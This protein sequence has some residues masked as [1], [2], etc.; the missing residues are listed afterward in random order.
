MGVAF[1]GDKKMY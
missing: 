1:S